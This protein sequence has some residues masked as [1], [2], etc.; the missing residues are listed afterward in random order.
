[1]HFQVAALREE[2]RALDADLPVFAI[3][4]LDARGCLSG[5]P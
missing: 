4:T 3:Q 1:M 5:A 2:L